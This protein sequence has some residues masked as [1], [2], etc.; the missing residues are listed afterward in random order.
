MPPSEQDMLLLSRI[1]HGTKKLYVMEQS[2]I[3]DLVA[4]DK[5][6][7]KEKLELEPSC[8]ETIDSVLRHLMESRDTRLYCP[9]LIEAIIR[10][11]GYSLAGGHFIGAMV[12]MSLSS[13]RAGEMS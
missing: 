10:A 1:A 9:F 2:L 13:R 11:R 4:L 12:S 6:L 3:N 5:R 7:E 8:V